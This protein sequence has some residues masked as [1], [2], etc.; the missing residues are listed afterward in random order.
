[1][2]RDIDE[3]TTIASLLTIE[4]GLQRPSVK[5]RQK[6]GPT[7]ASYLPWLIW[8]YGW[9]QTGKGAPMLYAVIKVGNAWGSLPQWIILLT[10][11]RNSA[12]SALHFGIPPV[13]VCGP[14]VQRRSVQLSIL[15]SRPGPGRTLTGIG[16]VPQSNFSGRDVATRRG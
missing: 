2:V 10:T 15:P 14:A 16:N 5:C 13:S 7:K 12:G 1:M 6:S 3:Y 11:A 9:L 4:N 8:K